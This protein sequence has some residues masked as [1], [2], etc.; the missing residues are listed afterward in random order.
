MTKFMFLLKIK[1]KKSF[2][3]GLLSNDF[4]FNGNIEYIGF[5][6]PIKSYNNNENNK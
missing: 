4:D 1:N 5:I 6:R 3:F 2:Q